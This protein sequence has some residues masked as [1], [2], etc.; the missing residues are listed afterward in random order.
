[1]STVIYMSQPFLSSIYIDPLLQE[2][3][4]IYIDDL[5]AGYKETHKG[6]LEGVSEWQRRSRWKGVRHLDIGWWDDPMWCILT[7]G[8]RR[9]AV[10]AD[11]ARGKIGTVAE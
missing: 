10:S 4:V 11:D 9:S 7:G 8:C 5:F 2:G 1:M 3:A 6:R